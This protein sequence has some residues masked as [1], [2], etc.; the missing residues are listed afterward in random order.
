MTTDTKYLWLAFD[1][2]AARLQE[3]SVRSAPLGARRDAEQTYAA[4]YDAL[5]RAG[6]AQPLRGKYRSGR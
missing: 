2:A 6:Q 3:L 5:A 1:R 4:A